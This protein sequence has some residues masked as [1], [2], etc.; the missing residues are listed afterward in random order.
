MQVVNGTVIQGKLVL[1]DAD[2]PEGAEVT[3]L[4]REQGSPVRLPADLQAELE[5]AL[6]EADRTEGISAE[7]LFA[8]L[9]KYG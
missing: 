7:D 4:V 9:R 5:E 1:E 2:L 3:V 8:Q 6:D